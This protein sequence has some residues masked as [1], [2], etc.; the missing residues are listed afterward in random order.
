MKRLLESPSQVAGASPFYEGMRLLG[1]RTPELSLI[2]LRLVL[3]GKRADDASVTGLRSIIER[4]RRGDAQAR[5]EY[6]DTL[7]AA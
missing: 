3:A 6:R 2:A 1:K 7:G 5:D 4:A